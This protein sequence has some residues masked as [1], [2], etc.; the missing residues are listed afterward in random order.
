[1]YISFSFFYHLFKKSST[2]IP[3]ND[4]AICE[5]I[6]ED[7]E[8]SPNRSK[9][10]NPRSN[11]KT[12]S[13]DIKRTKGKHAEENQIKRSDSESIQSRRKDSGVSSSD[14]DKIIFVRRAR[15]RKSVLKWN[16]FNSFFSLFI[17]NMGSV[18]TEHFY[19]IGLKIII[20]LNKLQWPNELTEGLIYLGFL[21]KLSFWLIIDRTATMYCKIRT[22]NMYSQ[23]I[24]CLRI[25]QLLANGAWLSQSILVLIAI[26]GPNQRCIIEKAHQKD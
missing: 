1:M 24:K 9:P 7:Q 20:F 12:D 8:T 23:L 2:R 26:F 19:M 18:Q 6:P 13:S 17:L 15:R 11:R 25:M 16:K 3:S 21:G 10:A 4:S 5:D 14:E 22:C